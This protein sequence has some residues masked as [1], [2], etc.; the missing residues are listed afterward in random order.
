MKSQLHRRRAAWLLCLGTLALAQAESIPTR[1][2]VD[3]RIRV[4]TYNAEEVYRLTGYVGY[5]L[6]FEFAADERFVGLAAGDVKGLSFESEANHLFL[7][8]TAAGVLTNLTILTTHHHY[9]VDYAV[10]SGRPEAAHA[11]VV[12]ALRFEYPEELLHSDQAAAEAA[13]IA[14]ALRAPAAP[15]NWD[16]WYCGPPTLRPQAAYDDGFQTHL[17]FSDASE[18]PA[19]FIRNE[20]GSESLT[21]FTVTAQEVIIHRVAHQLILRR[22]HLVACLVNKGFG[23]AQQHASA[24]TISPQVLRATRTPAERELQGAER[25]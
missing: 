1:G 8:P 13:R 18:L 7:K 10:A 25:E 15:V 24:G 16:Y 11:E 5:Q 6:E 14:E 3:P 21:N 22:G 17:R 23:G 9:R 12:Y 20:D 2:S 19:L 4:V